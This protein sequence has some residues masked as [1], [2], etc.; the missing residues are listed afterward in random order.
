MDRATPRLSDGTDH[1]TCL[2]D[3]LGERGAV[4]PAHEGDSGV[5]EQD[6]DVESHHA[7]GFRGFGQA[8]LAG[9]RPAGD[10][11]GSRCRG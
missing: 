11:P 1:R 10:D 3:D 9:S 4:V 7:I 5:F 2:L 6:I 8:D